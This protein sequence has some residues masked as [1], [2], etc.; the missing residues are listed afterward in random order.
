LGL[1]CTTIY[2]WLA[3]YRCGGEN[4]LQARPVPGR[5]LKL[6]GRQLKW[7]YDTVTRKNP[8][9]LKFARALWT[10]QMMATLINDRFKVKL[11]AVSVGECLGL[12]NRELYT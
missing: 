6:T 11:S 10:R 4:A 9:Q 8:M 2:D 3:L 12:K 1:N 7:I 5:P